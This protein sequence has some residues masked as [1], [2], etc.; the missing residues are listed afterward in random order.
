MSSAAPDAFS[1]DV[2]WADSS[3]VFATPHGT[4]RWIEDGTVAVC[5][6]PLTHT[7]ATSTVRSLYASVRT[8]ARDV[9]RCGQQCRWQLRLP[10]ATTLVLSTDEVLRLHTLLDGTVAMLDLRHMLAEAN[11]D[12]PTSSSAPS[13]A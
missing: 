1:L 10:N 2:L 13:A 3:V 9:Y 5:L 11:I 4:A 7:M 6:E 12:H 8:L